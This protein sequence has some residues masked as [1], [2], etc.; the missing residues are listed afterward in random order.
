MKLNKDQKGRCGSATAL[1]DK[2]SA[3]A[4]SIAESPTTEVQDL[5]WMAPKHQT[6]NSKKENK[7]KTKKAKRKFMNFLP[8]PLPAPTN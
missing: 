5:M 8:A 2:G 3:A 7:K 6:I 1:V 4:R